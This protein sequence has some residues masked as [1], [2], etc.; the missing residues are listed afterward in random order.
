V[1]F[2]APRFIV[3]DDNVK[4][5]EAITQ[6]FQGMGAPCLGLRYDGSAALDPS[7]FRGVRCLFMDLHLVDGVA[8]SD[9]RRHFANIAAILEDTISATGGPFVLV[10]W[11]AHPEL[12][13]QLREYLDEKIDDAHSHARPLA[14]L[15]LSKEQF[16]DLTGGEIRSAKELKEAVHRVIVANPQI[17]ALLGWESDVLGAAADTLAELLKLVPIA[18]RLSTRYSGALDV[19]LSR[20]ARE[21]VGRPNVEV[22]RRTA[23]ASALSP[24]LADRILNQVISVETT[25]LWRTAVT[26]HDDLTL[27]NASKQEAGAINRMLHIALP[28][29]EA[30]SATSWGAV[31][32]LENAIW[33]SDERLSEIFDVSRAQLLGD[34]F[35]VKPED[36]D[37]CHP[38]LIRVG[39]ACDHAQKRRGPLTY[40]L[41]LE[42][43]RGLKR[44][45]KP[46]DAEWSSP[47]ISLPSGGDP[48]VLHV[49][50]RFAM[51]CRSGALGAASVRYRLREQ[52][53][54]SLLTHANGYTSRPG[55]I[56][57]PA[58]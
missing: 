43:P 8:S 55:I 15:G 30:I 13:T 46:S 14:L 37:K 28:S 35:K 18:D 38:R 52:L 44:K 10:V 7:H 33:L 58:D 48:F 2:S 50:V 6:T 20:L 53:L 34:E 47:V 21:A 9:H 57:L 39:A 36:F 24:I 42:M 45:N 11:T 26:R 31:V 4:H 1:I 32:Q 3:V 40:L 49:N 56:Q 54:M 51:T 41:G 23:I 29:S 27:A 25:E 5:L 17:A 12:Q 19:V 22:D 16:I